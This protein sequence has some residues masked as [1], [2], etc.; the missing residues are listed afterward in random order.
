MGRRATTRNG[1]DLYAP[2]R[3]HEDI[4]KSVLTLGG[5][6]HSLTVDDEGRGETARR[7]HRR[8]KREMEESF[9]PPTLKTLFRHESVEGHND[10][11]SRTQD[12]SEER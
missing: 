12:G 10:R 6:P 4:V 3:N 5:L 8:P 7:L 2:Q 11:P 9:H 1:R